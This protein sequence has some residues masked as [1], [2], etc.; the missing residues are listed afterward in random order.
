MSS[1]V[2]DT[3]SR[4]I[5]GPSVPVLDL[6]EV[7]KY[8]RFTPT[9]EDTLID[10][11][12]E[13]ATDYFE[14]QTGIIC[15]TQTWEFGLAATPADAEI[16][17]P[18][19]PLQSV[20]SVFGGDDEF[21]VA[22]YEVVT[23][24]VGAPR[25]GRVRLIGSSWPIVSEPQTGGLRITYKAG[26]GNQPGAIPKLIVI[27]IGMLMAHFHKFRAEVHEQTA[28]A[29]VQVPLGAEQI[30][31]DYKYGNVATLQP[32]GWWPWV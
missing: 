31:R 26:F 18:K 12:L 27:T 1:R 6:D 8:L 9:S 22:N 28:G 23:A 21:D 19:S 16:E 17:L 13:A 5:T 2:I 11:M 4:R 29:I 20:V 10:S 14:S 7:K 30:I 32:R 24:T 15:L 3:F 25:R